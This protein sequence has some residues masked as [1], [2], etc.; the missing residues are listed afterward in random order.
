MLRDGWKVP[1]MQ[2]LQWHRATHAVQ[3]RL[4]E[5]GAW[6][7]AGAAFAFVIPYVFSSLLDLT[8]NLYY[9]VYFSAALAFLGL[10]TTATALDVR[11]LF[12]RNWRASLA[13]GVL[14][15]LFLVVSVLRREDATP[16]PSGL[17]LLFSIVWR[18]L[19]YGLVDALLLTAF[20]VAVAL[21]IIDGRVDTLARHMAFAALAIGLSMGITATYHLGYEQYREDGLSAPETGN[22]IIGLP[23]FLSAN[24]LG[25]L[26]AHASM[27]VT[28]DIHAYETAV[29]LPPQTA[30]RGGAGFPAEVQLTEA[31]NGRQVQLARDGQLI[32]ALASNPSTG[33]GWTLLGEAPAFI[34]LDGEPRFLPAGSTLPLP[35]AP[36]T[37]VFTFVAAAEGSG[38]LGLGYLRPFESLP[39][40]RTFTVDVKVR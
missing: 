35:G 21:A 5:Q 25:S 32:I 15:A 1:D 34:R 6:Y 20:P 2:S 23:A 4:M 38:K 7:I 26:V 22:T 18:G 40:L 3:P 13:F 24:P 11:A 14:A 8:N 31:D 27:H 30:A 36:G 28:A 10:Y 9:L 39:P 19:T 33:Y 12:S 29:Y 17:E 16:H 37:Q